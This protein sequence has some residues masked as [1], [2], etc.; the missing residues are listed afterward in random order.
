MIFCQIEATPT[1][2]VVVAHIATNMLHKFDAAFPFTF[3]SKENI[4]DAEFS[5]NNAL[6]ILSGL[7]RHSVMTFAALFKRCRFMPRAGCY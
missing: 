2:V 3:M 6:L 1:I 7:K 5:R 4:F